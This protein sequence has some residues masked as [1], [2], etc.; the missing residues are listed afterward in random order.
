MKYRP[1][2]GSLSASM[3]EV[4]EVPNTIKD[5]KL[6]LEKEYPFID[7]IKVNPYW[8][9]SRINWDTHIVTINGSAVGFTDGGLDE[10]LG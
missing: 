6:A 4:I 2:R 3:A 10:H 9:D 7:E 1:Q 5:L 8:F